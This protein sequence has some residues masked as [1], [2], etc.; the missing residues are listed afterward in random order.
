MATLTEKS[1]KYL[2]IVLAVLLVI[3]SAFLIY[4]QYNTLVDLRAEVEEEELL[5]N[6]ARARL[7]RLIEHRNNAPEY[8]MR[9]EYARRM[10]PGEPGE[11]AMLRYIQRLANDYGLRAVDIR[12]ANRSV[13]DDFTTMPMTITIEGSYPDLQRVLRQLRDGNRAVRVD[14]IRISRAGGAG[15][16]LRVTLSAATFYNQNN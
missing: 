3:L 1:K 14:D 12:F 13:Q 2:V 10:I 8:E 11:D 5:L 16:Q 4:M 9:L 7:N 15:S 6:A